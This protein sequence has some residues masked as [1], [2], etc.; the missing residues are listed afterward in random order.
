MVASLAGCAEKKVSYMPVPFS[1]LP[2]WGD[3][4]L[5]D[6]PTLE[7]EDARKYIE[8]NFQPYRVTATGNEAGLFTGYYEP[9][10]QGSRTQHGP[11]QTPIY[12]N[13][14]AEIHFTRGE[15]MEG[16][17]DGQDLELL[18]VTSP[19]DAFFMAVQGSGCV[20]L[21]TGET[22]R[23]SYYGR[24]SHAYAS[25]G[26][27]MIKQAM[28]SRDDMSMDAIRNWFQQHPDR[29]SE[30]LQ[31]NPSYIFFRE[32]PG[33][34]PVGSQGVPLTPKRSMAVDRDYY[35]YGT[36][37]WV[38]LDYQ[39]IQRLMIAQD[40]GSAIKGPIR[41]DFFWGTGDEAGTLAGNMKSRGTL[42]VLKPREQAR[43]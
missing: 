23:L 17:L 8:S 26:S 37:L 36:L 4:D 35:D 32:N 41:G 5:R 19:V 31:Q 22:V 11:Y 9:V 43:S 40:T 42:Y 2:G 34:G 27:Y 7:T 6:I 25:I 24:N 14:D 15:I 29:I 20:Q 21:D 16:A 18:W 12:R 30:V 39:G 1:E 3:D 38:D 10:L 13:P 33:S 28:V